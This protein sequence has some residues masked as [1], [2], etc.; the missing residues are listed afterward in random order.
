MADLFGSLDDGHLFV[1]V[2]GPGYGESIIVRVPPGNHAAAKWIVIDGCLINHKSPA[3]EILR[4]HGVN[5]ADCAILT[6][7]HL[8][9][10]KG[11][12]EVIDMGGDGILGCAD[13]TMDEAAAAAASTDATGRQKVQVV[14]SLLTAIAT[15][16]SGNA[17]R[18]W[19][20]RREDPRREIGDAVLEVLH[21]DDAAVA[22]YGGCTETANR[23]SGAVR[24]TWQGVT[25]LLAGDVMKP[26]WDDISK[27]SGDLTAHQL[28]KVPHHGSL[29]AQHDCFGKVEAPHPAWVATPWS[30][31]SGLP[32]FVEDQGM[33]WL[34]DR[35][36]ILH[37]TAL[38]QKFK[39]QQMRPPYRVT[40]ADLA[41][42]NLPPACG[43][44]LPYTLGFA[45]KAEYDDVNCCW[46]CAAFRPDGTLANLGH[47]PGSIEIVRS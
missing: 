30:K 11:L 31:G 16:W 4:R 32:Q 36:P 5:G 9:H 39:L 37:L 22:K 28:L 17:G 27:H 26:D 38:P 29:E 35:N 20:M 45:E 1:G 44:A 47:G 24:L 33:N 7:A 42:N 3:A 34:I 23:I 43:E 13:L 41:A 6:H 46:V 10:A 19:R 15:A 2:Y 40:A 14:R 18:V 8:D 12:Q 21:P 25:L